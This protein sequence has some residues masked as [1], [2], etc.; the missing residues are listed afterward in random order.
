MPSC[1]ELSSFAVFLNSVESALSR[2]GKLVP[3]SGLFLSC[4]VFDVSPSRARV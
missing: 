1:S 3:E 2:L 4:W